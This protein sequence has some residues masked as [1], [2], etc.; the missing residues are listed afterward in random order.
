MNGR[1]DANDFNEL[2]K[3]YAFSDKKV[4]KLYSTLPTVLSIAGD[5]HGKRV[6][7]LG[8]GSGFFAREASDLGGIVI[9]LDNSLGQLERARSA[10]GD[11]L[12]LERDIFLHPFP[13]S[14]LILA[15]YVANYAQSVRELSLLLYRAYEALPF[16]GILILVLDEPVRDDKR[17]FGF[18]KEF[19]DSDRPCS[20][21]D[22]IR[23]GL[24]VE[25]QEICSL[26]SYYFSFETVCSLLKRSGFRFIRKHKPIVAEDGIRKMG[27]RFWDGYVEDSGFIYLCAQK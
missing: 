5:M 3:P 13:A 2:S 7:D 17:R 20:D 14:D 25:E 10:G 16:Q 24:Y 6:L 19:L 22:I 15:P 8:C 18:T 12:Y 1:I 23:V 21:G 11:I 26:R 9:G 27:S 4:D